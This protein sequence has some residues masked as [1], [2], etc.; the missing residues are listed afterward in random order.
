MADHKP[1]K[2][3]PPRWAMIYMLVIV[4]CAIAWIILPPVPAALLTLMGVSASGTARAAANNP[5]PGGRTVRGQCAQP[6]AATYCCGD[7]LYNFTESGLL[8]TRS[9][10]HRPRT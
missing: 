3:Y 7:S 2:P 5:G 1:G 8:S 10:T 9:N 4:L 6:S